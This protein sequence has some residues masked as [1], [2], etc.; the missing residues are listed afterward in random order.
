MRYIPITDQDIQ[1]MLKET[2]LSSVESLF[3]SIPSSI[4]FKQDLALPMPLDEMELE[5]HARQIASKNST[6]QTHDTFIG[7]INYQHFIPSIVDTLSSNSAFYTAYTPYQPEVSQGTLEAIYQFQ[8]YMTHLTGMDFSNASLYDGATAAAEALYMLTSSSRKKRAVLSSTLHPHV[9]EVIRTY[10]KMRN[11]EIEEIHSNDGTLA[12][13]DAEDKFTEQTAC[14]IV[15]IPNVFGLI[16]DLKPLYD[17]LSEK[18]IKLVVVILEPMLLGA[19]MPYDPARVDIVCGEAQTFGIE[20]CYGGPGLGFF[21]GKK[22]LI[23]KIPGRIVGKTTD[24][25]GREAYVMTLR[26]REQDI[27]REKATSNICTNHALN[28]LRATIYL[29]TVG[30]DGLKAIARE[31][32]NISHYAIDRI[33]KETP[34]QIPYKK[35]YFNE[36][37]VKIPTPHTHQ[38]MIKKLYEKNIL[39]SKNNMGRFFPYLGESFVISF[40]EI[41]QISQIDNL[42]LALKEVLS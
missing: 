26:A 15:Q 7:E 12:I 32:I 2:N 5:R 33:E 11:I 9:K 38:E 36:I 1:D 23:R 10:A 13:H 17:K 31:N 37:L 16:E 14:F 28:A 24:K 4:R 30:E 42:I 20:T 18:K 29:S 6:S 19:L 25:E 39:I 8:S 34:C 3:Q 40:S 22:E 41:H 27:R 35:P 21:T